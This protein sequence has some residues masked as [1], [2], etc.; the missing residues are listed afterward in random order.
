MDKLETTPPRKDTLNAKTTN[1]A[2]LIDPTATVR[3]SRTATDSAEAQPSPDAGPPGSGKDDTV[4]RELD[5]ARDP[6]RS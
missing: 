2:A 6:A 1:A 3:V 5:P 4:R